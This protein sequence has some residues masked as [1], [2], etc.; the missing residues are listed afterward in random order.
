MEPTLRSGILLAPF[1]PADEDPTLAM[2]GRLG[3][4]HCLQLSALSP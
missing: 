3:P 4:A 1:R 2:P